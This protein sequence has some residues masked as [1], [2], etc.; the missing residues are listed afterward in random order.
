MG[1]VAERVDRDHQSMTYEG[2]RAAGRSAEQSDPHST[3]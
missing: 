3:G 2:D 1:S